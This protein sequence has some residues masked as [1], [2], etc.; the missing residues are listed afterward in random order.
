MDILAVEEN[1]EVSLGTCRGLAVG[2]SCA[3]T[4]VF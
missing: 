3:G 4:R 2:V 1:I